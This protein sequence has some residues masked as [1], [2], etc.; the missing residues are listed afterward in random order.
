MPKEFQLKSNKSNLLIESEREK[1]E[2]FGT[3]SPDQEEDNVKK[4]FNPYKKVLAHRNSQ[5]LQEEKMRI[6]AYKDKESLPT[7]QEES[8]TEPLMMTQ[9]SM[10]K[11]KKKLGSIIPDR[12]IQSPQHAIE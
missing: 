12:Q 6:S 3:V 4:N 5:E 2:E 7:S 11:L 9:T 10:K 8:Y 1:I